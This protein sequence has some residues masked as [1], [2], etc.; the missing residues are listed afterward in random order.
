[1]ESCVDNKDM[2]GLTSLT[3]IE[4][5]KGL[6]EPQWMSS[7]NHNRKQILETMC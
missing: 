7:F 6:A 4:Q 2:C 3:S 5:N 1:M